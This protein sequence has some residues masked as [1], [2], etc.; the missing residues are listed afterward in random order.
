MQ[1]KTTGID[2]YLPGGEAN[3]KTMV[4]G[5]PGAGKTRWSSFW[6]EPLYLNCEAGLAAVADRNVPYVDIDSSEDMLRALR[7]LKR[8][9]DARKFGTVV[10]DTLD[11]FQRKV[12]DEW[13]LANPSASAFGGYD[14]W[15]YL[16]A[17]MQA[18]MT[19]LLSLD[20]NVI[21]LVHY[22]DKT[23]TEKVGSNTIERHFFQLQL[24]GDIKDSAFNDFDLVGWMDTYWESQE[25][26]GAIERVQKRGITFQPT[27]DRPFLKDR[28][29][30]TPT[31]LEVKFAES[32]YVDLFERF[33]SRVDELGEGE[34]LGEVEDMPDEEMAAEDVRKPTKGGPVAPQD[35]RDRPLK[36]MTKPDL[37]AHAKEQHGLELKQ[38]MLKDE[39]VAAIEAERAKPKEAKEESEP[40]TEASDASSSEAPESAPEKAEEPSTSVEGEPDNEGQSAED[41]I[42]TETPREA[43]EGDAT[44]PEE[45]IKKELGGEVVSESSPSDAQKHEPQEPQQEAKP[46][47][48]GEVCEECG[49][50]LGGESSDLVKLAYIKFRKKLC[51]LHYREAKAEAK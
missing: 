50:D 27:P 49:K 15:G 45:A 42:A 29:H 47:S 10:V 22:K 41:A 51:N 12:K 3:I 7:W 4:I 44:D 13:L 19:R 48:S 43:T 46:E 33:M 37:M 8:H 39:M 6:P 5:G 28:L 34:S 36:D 16:D 38:A 18:L 24:Q 21:V 40:E 11:T 31:W 20:K 30:I 32:D 17:K 2:Q 14:A 35:P 9:P 26:D 23:V 1:I 25:V